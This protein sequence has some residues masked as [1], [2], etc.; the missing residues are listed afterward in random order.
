[1]FGFIIAL[2]SYNEHNE[3][4]ATDDDERVK[5]RHTEQPVAT[6]MPNECRSTH[7]RSYTIHEVQSQC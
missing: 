2:N 4:L 1:M 5:E 3:R 7:I 6:T